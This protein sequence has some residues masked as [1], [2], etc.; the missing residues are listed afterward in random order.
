MVVIII[1]I[2]DNM[3]NGFSESLLSFSPMM[4]GRRVS[5]SPSNP[6]SLI[7]SSFNYEVKIGPRR[8]H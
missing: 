5:F 1:G 7:I 4:K 2:L 3:G 6:P 8:E